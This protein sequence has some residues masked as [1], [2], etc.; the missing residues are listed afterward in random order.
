MVAIITWEVGKKKKGKR[1]SIR[2]RGRVFIRLLPVLMADK[3]SGTLTVEE[4]TADMYINTEPT[5]EPSTVAPLE[6]VQVKDAT[7]QNRGEADDTPHYKI[8]VNA[9]V[10]YDSD[11][12]SGILKAGNYRTKTWE[13]TAPSYEGTYTVT[14]KVWGKNTESEPS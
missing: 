4:K 6:K 10:A 2:G 11:D 1:N 5:L 7:I 9:T 14:L 8:L 3:W 13:F 12:P